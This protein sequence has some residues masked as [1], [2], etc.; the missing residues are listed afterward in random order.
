MK[1]KNLNQYAILAV[2][3]VLLLSGCA[4]STDISKCIVESP[5]GFWSGLWHGFIAPISF[6]GSLFWDS[7]DMY[8]K[9]NTGGWYDFGFLIGVGAF[10]GGST[11][12]S[13]R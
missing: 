12:G 7:I 3:A 2:L 5:Y 4:H 9:N 1:T 8:A 10:S 11:Y 6:I 13:T